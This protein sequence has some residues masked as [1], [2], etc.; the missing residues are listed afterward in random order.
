[1]K[2]PQKR[3]AGTLQETYY[4]HNTQT[5][6]NLHLQRKESGVQDKTMMKLTEEIAREIT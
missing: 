2:T 3:G 5:K 1:M 6:L 4:S